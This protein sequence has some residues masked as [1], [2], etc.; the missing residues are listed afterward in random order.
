VTAAPETAEMH[1]PE[2]RPEIPDIRLDSVEKRYLAKGSDVL[3]LSDINLSVRHNGCVVLRGPS[4]CGKSTLLRIIAGLLRPS[5]GS[6]QIY[7]QDLWSGEQR[8]R[9]VVQELGVVF[10]DAN[11]FPWFNAEQNIALP[12]R[13]RGMAKRD[14]LAKARALCELVGVNGFEKR[15]PRELSGGMRQRVAIA[16]ALSYD[17]RILLMD[18]PFGSLDALTRDQMNLEIQRIWTERACTIVLVTHSITEAVFLGNRVVLLTP[19]PGRID[20]IT[21]VDFPRPRSL[22]LQATIGFQEI[23]KDLRH[24]L[25]TAP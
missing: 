7:G 6:M 18:E 20:S 10:Q 2:A 3:A 4:G 11:L 22:D 12:L 9:D 16:R 15:L 1:R 25:G 21:E 17:P 13:L 24:R 19:R 8:N 23:V 14:R 5:A